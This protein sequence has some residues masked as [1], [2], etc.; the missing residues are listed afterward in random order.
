ME[1]RKAT[2]SDSTR[3]VDLLNQLGYPG[4]EQFITKKILQ[5]TGDP[6]EELLVAA[7]D[8]EVLGFI[9]IHFV[10]QIALPGAFARISYLCVDEKARGRGIGRQLESYCE[11]LARNRNCDRIEL[12]CNYR[13]K[14]AH[15]FYYRQGYE[16]S[17]KYLMKKL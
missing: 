9:S 8:G 13:R 10:P 5:L 17:P 14:R 16:E 3:I 1:I 6:D 4:T 12:H 2:V 11:N 7:E 15:R